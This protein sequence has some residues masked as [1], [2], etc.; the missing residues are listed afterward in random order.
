MVTVQM[1][2]E[3]NAGLSL[4]AEVLRY[5]MEF[6]A[7]EGVTLMELKKMIDERGI[8]PIGEGK[9]GFL[10]IVV[11]SDLLVDGVPKCK[12]PRFYNGIAPLFYGVNSS[13][14]D[15]ELDT[16]IERLAPRFG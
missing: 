3:S 14:F 16:M 12:V 15:E 8:L 6:Y 4:T 11:K 1:E 2:L 10:A 13:K 5:I 9:H 7:S